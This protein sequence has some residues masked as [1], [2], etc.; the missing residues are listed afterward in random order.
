MSQSKA[1][2]RAKRRAKGS[3]R[4]PRTMSPTGFYSRLRSLLQKK[5]VQGYRSGLGGDAKG[6]DDRLFLI[7]RD[8]VNRS[9]CLAQ[10]RCSCRPFHD[11]SRRRS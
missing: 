2:S 5:D 11:A 10:R 7:A 1:K 6:S 3:C 8:R 4:R 9:D